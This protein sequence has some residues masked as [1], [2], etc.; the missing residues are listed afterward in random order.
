MARPTEAIPSCPTRVQ[1]QR[2]LRR[3]CAGETPASLLRGRTRSGKTVPDLACKSSLPTRQ[4]RGGRARKGES[5][6][7]EVTVSPGN[8]PGHSTFLEG[9]RVVLRG[10]NTTWEAQ[11]RWHAIFGQ[12]RDDRE[13]TNADGGQ[14]NDGQGNGTTRAGPLL[15]RCGLPG[16]PFLGS[17]F[18][19]TA[20]VPLRTQ[21]PTARRWDRFIRRFRA[22][23][24]ESGSA[25]VVVR[26]II[27]VF[28]IRRKVDTLQEMRNSKK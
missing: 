25:D 8:G 15:G 22:A 20:P 4:S 24:C 10:L 26:R 17:T 23:L 14:G 11:G 6:R 5:D 21:M 18:A 27:R 2:K 9:N 3:T 19:T 12:G 16:P 28:P 1:Q 7:G 13:A